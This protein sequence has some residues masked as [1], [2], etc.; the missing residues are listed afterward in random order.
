VWLISM[1]KNQN[2]Q[3]NLMKASN[4]NLRK[5]M[6]SYLGGDTRSRIDGETDRHDP[7]VRL[8]TLY[9]TKYI[10]NSIPGSLWSEICILRVGSRDIG[11]RCVWVWSLLEFLLPAS[12]GVSAWLILDPWRW[13]HHVVPK[14]WFN[15]S[16]VYGLISQ[17]VEIFITT[18]VSTSNPVF[19]LCACD[20]ERG[21]WNL[22]AVLF[23]R[24]SIVTC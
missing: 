11:L 3:T 6:S 20:R 4:V 19:V 9:L 14:C 7:Q 17:K 12:R 5:I 22:E 1:A 8:S 18:A 21:N 24:S 2:R 16:G 13:R 10:N 15:F 23:P